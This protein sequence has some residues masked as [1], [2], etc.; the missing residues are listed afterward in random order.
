MNRWV[1]QVCKKYADRV[2]VR[3]SFKY[4]DVL[5]LSKERQEKYR[6]QGVGVGSR[7]IL[8]ENNS[9]LFLGKLHALWELSAVPCLIP[10]RL[11]EDKKKECREI[12]MKKSNDEYLSYE[13]IDG[14]LM[15]TSGTTSLIPKAVRL[16]HSNLLC[17]IEM[18]R[19]HISMGM[20]NEND[21]TFSLLPWT[22]CYGLMGECFSV[23]DR[24]ASMGVL[25]NQVKFSFPIFFKDLQMTQPTILFVVPHLLEVILRYDGYLRKYITNPN[26]RRQFWFGSKLRYIVSGG[27]YLSQDVRREYFQELGVEILQGYGCTEMSPMIALQ[28][29]F[30]IED[31]S[32]GKL[33]PNIQI[34]FGENDEIHVNGLNRFSGY[35]HSREIPFHSFYNTKDCG[36]INNNK[37]YIT[38][39]S[40]DVI[41]LTNG[42]FINTKDINEFLK[43]RIQNITNICSWQEYG[44][45]YSI[46]FIDNQQ[47]QQHRTEYFH[48]Q[49]I[50]ILCLPKSFLTPSLLTIKGELSRPLIQSSFSHL[51]NKK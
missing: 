26:R 31:R 22:H 35:L 44:K 9:I 38:G 39:R 33:L 36:Y 41:K 11:T 6:R 16:T 13:K 27:A 42:R 40:S 24:G 19:E 25:S 47:Q 43:T 21:T 15:M 32:V 30:D 28:Q 48:G 29:E 17:H 37:L 45:L 46:L 5:I 18:L 4:S 50:Q 51:L 20:M 8:S 34:E 14:L 23:M 7:V 12:I 2:L 10:P 1:T 3:P 49:P